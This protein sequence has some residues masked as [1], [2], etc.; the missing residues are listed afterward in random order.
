MNAI[1]KATLGQLQCIV[2]GQNSQLITGF[3]FSPTG[4][5]CTL[6]LYQNKDT[7]DQMLLSTHVDDFLLAS[8]FLMLVQAF[9]LYFGKRFKCKMSVAREFVGLHISEIV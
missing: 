8:T 6:C 9:A 4:S 5:G 7:D 3:G 1:L 2:I